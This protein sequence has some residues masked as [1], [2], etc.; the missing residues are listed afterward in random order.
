MLVVL[1]VDWYGDSV[2]FWIKMLSVELSFVFAS[3]G[4][5]AF[6][7]LLFVVDGESVGR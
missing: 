4:Y 1:F 3:K 6:C 5:E 7:F 2:V